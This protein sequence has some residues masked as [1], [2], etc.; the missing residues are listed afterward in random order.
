MFKRLKRPLRKLIPVRRKA[1]KMRVQFMADGVG[2]AG[3]NTSFLEDQRFKAAWNRA[4]E[5]NREGWHGQVPDIR[6]RAHTACWAAE[7]ALHLEGAFVECGVHTGLLSITICEY[8]GL[9]ENNKDFWLFDTFDGIPTAS[10][11]SSERA[12]VEELNKSIYFDVWALARRNFAAYP[13]AHLVRGFLPDTLAD[14]NLDKVAYLSI[15]LNNVAAEKAVIEKL[16][17]KIVPGGLVLLD[18]YAFSG[19]EAQ[20]QMWNDFAKSIKRPILTIPTGQG[21]LIR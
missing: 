10:L 1:K 13:R 3:K 19:Y 5:L 17:E 2:V 21:L 14:A 6:W 12:H 9:N 20:H 15:D 16:W 11:L 7:Q 8:L 4:V 18:D